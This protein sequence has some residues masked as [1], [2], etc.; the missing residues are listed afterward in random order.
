MKV[1]ALTIAKIRAASAELTLA[2]T[3]IADARQAL[4]TAAQAEADAIADYNAAHIDAGLDPAKVTALVRDVNGPQGKVLAG[5]VITIN[6]ANG[7]GGGQL[8]EPP[9]APAPV[10][11]LSS[12]DKA[13]LL[14]EIKDAAA[15]T[16][17]D[18]DLI[19]PS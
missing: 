3:Q 17:N 1:D 6:D 16:T 14:A 8:W 13:K 9:A 11:E 19:A 10:V 5:T 12:A 15:A 7:Q 2:R 4:Q 18:I